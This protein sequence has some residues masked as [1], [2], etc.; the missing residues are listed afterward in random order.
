MY[1]VK[2][3]KKFYEI[4]VVGVLKDDC[5]CLQNNG[6]LKDCTNLFDYLFDDFKVDEELYEMSKEDFKILLSDIWYEISDYNDGMDM[7]IIP[8]FSDN[9]IESYSLYLNDRKLGERD[10]D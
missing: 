4:A 7:A 9:D 3:G 10:F 5:E 1:A 6:C 8:N 2:V